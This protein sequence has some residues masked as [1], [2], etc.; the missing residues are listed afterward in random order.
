MKHV[1]GLLSNVVHNGL[2]L[3]YFVSVFGILVAIGR[4]GSIF[5]LSNYWFV[6]SERDLP[7]Q[8]KLHPRDERRLGATPH[9]QGPTPGV[10]GEAPQGLQG[11]FGA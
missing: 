8:V 5:L 11:A 10:A 6:G 4:F 3:A 2:G 9:S 7:Y 1:V